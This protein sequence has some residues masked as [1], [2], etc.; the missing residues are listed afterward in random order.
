MDALRRRRD[1]PAAAP[2]PTSRRTWRPRRRRRCT[3]ARYRVV[4]T[5]GSTGR[6][7][8]VRRRPRRVAHLPGRP[9]ADQRV[10]RACARA[11]RA[12]GGSR[13]SPPRRPGARHLPDV[14]Q[15]RRRASH[16][17]L[18]LDATDAVDRLVARLNAFRPE[19][20]YGY[21]SV[22][23]LLAA[24]QL[25]GRLR[26][27]PTTLASSGETHTADTERAVRAGVGRPVV[28]DLRDHRAAGARR[29][30]RPAQPACTCSRT[31]RSSRSST[32]TTGRS[33]PG[34]PG[35][36][37]LVTNLVARAQ[38]LIRYAV[39][40]LVTAGAE[41]CPCGRPYP[42]AARGRGPQRRH[43]AAAR[44]RAAAG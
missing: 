16:R 27:A 34:Q 32:S 19:F 28:P 31:W 24:E 6:R 41:P 25:D 29:A 23:E 9:A 33:P 3:S 2:A 30:L 12:A 21:P 26:I 38:P 20:L 40:D 15:P 44:R 22:L 37:L 17:V 43:P 39:T 36:R 13:P 5:G 8:R 35:H 7:G 42:P 10:P 18:R 14:A 4:A 1:R 11:C